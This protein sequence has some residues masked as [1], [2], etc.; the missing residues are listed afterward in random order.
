MF[1]IYKL[2]THKIMFFLKFSFGFILGIFLKFRKFHPRY[3]HKPYN[4]SCDEN[5][6]RGYDSLYWDLLVVE[7]IVDVPSHFAWVVCPS[8]MWIY[9]RLPAWHSSSNIWNDWRLIAVGVDLCQLGLASTWTSKHITTACVWG[10]KK[11]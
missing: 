5:E 8:W 1:S 10:W 6:R 3:F 2:S 9:K 11:L 4:F 7:L